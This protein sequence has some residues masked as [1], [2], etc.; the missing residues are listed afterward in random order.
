M[1]RKLT[2]GNLSTRLAALNHKF[3]L[4]GQNTRIQTLE[5]RHEAG[6]TA[7]WIHLIVSEPTDPSVRTADDL[8]KFLV[9]GSSRL[10]LVLKQLLDWQCLEPVDK[11]S[12]KHHQTL[13]L[14]DV[15]PLN[16]WFTGI[17]LRAA[18]G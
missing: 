13:L 10:R 3:E 18:L 1:L 15:Y 4:G 14:A 12:Y 11:A 5:K 17:V 2:L 16:A 9:E 6:L 8:I 7:E